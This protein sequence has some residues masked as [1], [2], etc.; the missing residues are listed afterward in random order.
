MVSSLL[1]TVWFVSIIQRW[2]LVVFP[3]VVAVI[4]FVVAKRL[5]HHNPISAGLRLVVRCVSKWVHSPHVVWQC[6]CSIL[7]NKGGSKSQFLCKLNRAIS[8]QF[9]SEI[10]LSRIQMHLASLIICWVCTPPPRIHLVGLSVCLSDFWCLSG[11]APLSFFLSLSASLCLTH[12]LL[13]YKNN[14]YWLPV[15]SFNVQQFQSNFVL[16]QM[17]S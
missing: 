11:Y 15:L 10:L 5:W 6:H 12:T 14:V 13:V 3:F 1:T 4:Y 16:K 9:H 7:C 8:V 2:L 17:R